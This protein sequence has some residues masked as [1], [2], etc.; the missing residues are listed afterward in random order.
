MS[1]APTT[2]ALPQYR[3]K[4]LA[5][6]GEVKMIDRNPD[7]KLL[8]MEA[9]RLWLPNDVKVNVT[10]EW[11]QTHAAHAGGYFLEFDDGYRSF[12]PARAFL[13]GYEQVA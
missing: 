12:C 6:A 3:S 11:I 7:V 2:A 13:A 9:Y 5:R 4:R 10:E 8:T 1:E